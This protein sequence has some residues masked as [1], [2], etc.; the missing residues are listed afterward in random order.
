MRLSEFWVLPF[1]PFFQEKQISHQAW[2]LSFGTVNELHEIDDVQKGGERVE[3][4]EP[5]WL[6]P[7]ETLLITDY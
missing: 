1:E 5:H 7:L 2:S 3:R 4:C 6:L